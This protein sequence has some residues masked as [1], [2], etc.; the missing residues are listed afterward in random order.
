MPTRSL[1]A[2][3]FSKLPAERTGIDI[4]EPLTMREVDA[5]DR[6]RLARLLLDSYAGTIDDENGTMEEAGVEIDNFLKGEYGEPL[7]DASVVAADAGGVPR[8]GVLITRWG[9]QGY[10]LV[11]FV[12]T[13]PAFQGKGIA[14]AL[15]SESLRRM[16]ENGEEE[17]RAAI[18][19]G[20]TASEKLFERVGFLRIE[21]FES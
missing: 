3:T 2:L 18:T 4:P 9:R 6:D 13:E 21:T 5:G 17:A 12:M 19:V 1:Y 16:K 10:P 20:N 15:L 11:A 8:S 7:L 14:R